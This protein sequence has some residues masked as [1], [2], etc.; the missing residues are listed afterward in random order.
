MSRDS[1]IFSISLSLSLSLFSSVALTSSS[2]RAVEL[3]HPFLQ[4]NIPQAF[5]DV[6]PGTNMIRERR[7]RRSRK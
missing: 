4:G 5:R 7:A 1:C 2:L 3:N 6:V